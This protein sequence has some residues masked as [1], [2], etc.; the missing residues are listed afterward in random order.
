MSVLTLIQSHCKRHALAVPTAVVGTADV[1]VKQLLET[2]I[3]TTEE[4]VTEAKFNVTTIETTFTA[5]A[6]ESQG[7]LS[8][9]AA[10]GYQYIINGTLWD[11]TKDMPLYGPVDEPEW[12][13]L[14]AIT[15]S[16]PNYAYRIRGGLL[17]FNPVPAAPLP[18]I[19][20]EYVSSWCVTAANGTLK[21]GITLD[22]DL[23]LFPDNL[24]KKGLAFRW[25]RDKG[26]PYQADEATYY[27]LLNKYVSRDKTK[28]P[29][30]VAGWDDRSAHPQIVVSSGSWLQ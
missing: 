24:L 7:A 6:A 12:Q 23:F 11:R 2:L 29:V 30:N 9:L 17:L 5:V 13:R 22:S 28:R 27:D 15:N 19:A 10:S 18:T 26:L 1:T 16:G 8:T 14:K 20:F 25:K 21:S 4:I 3:E